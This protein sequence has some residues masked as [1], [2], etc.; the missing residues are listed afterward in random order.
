MADEKQEVK[1][2]SVPE[3]IL[4]LLEAEGIRT[5]IG[6]PDP[7][8]ITMHTLAAKR[9]WDVIAPHHEQTGVF[10][11]DGIWRM[12]GKPAVVIGNEGPGVANLLPGAVCA[13]K[14]NTPVI[15]IA[16]Q[17]RRALDAQVARGRFQYTPQPRFFEP[18]MKFVGIIEFP[19]QVDEIFH[20]AFRAAMS[21]TPGPVYIEYPED[22]LS[23]KL[24]VK[25]VKK[26][27]QYR[28][29]RRKADHD[30]VEAAAD[31]ICQSKNPVFLIGAGVF[32][33]RAHDA[34]AKLAKLVPCPIIK[35]PA[36]G[37]TIPGMEH[38]SFPY[39][40]PM[41]NEAIA[42]SD[43]VI[44]IGTE[45]GEP[46]H[47]GF[48]YHWSKGNVDR[49][50]VR[51]ERDEKAMQANR[52]IDAPLLGDL[53]DVIPQLTDALAKRS[54]IASNPKTAIWAKQ[55]A[56][57]NQMMIDK[58]PHTS[59]VHP[60]RMV[61]E[62]TKVLPKDT[63]LIRDGGASSM[64]TG[65]YNQCQ[66]SDIFW[67]SNFGHLGTGLPHAIGAQLAVGKNRRVCLITG[68]S[69]LL[70]HI[71]E[72]ETAVR[73]KLPVVVIVNSDSAWGLEV[74][75]Y[76]QVMGPDSGETEAHWGPVRF[77]KIA[78]GFGA[79]GEYVDKSENVGPAVIRA[80][81]SGR[82]A[83]VQVAVDARVNALRA[84]GAAEFATWYGGGLY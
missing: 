64:W 40:Y 61:I 42:E 57:A 3:R 23:K 36:A 22:N 82:P 67:C 33:N 25:P 37:S 35:T 39:S 4:Q 65:A 76:N 69:A 6:I 77:D 16:G 10:M 26:P 5:L 8:F 70:F 27:E 52:P 28:L 45:L 46:I 83:L 20:E 56:E 48:K 51:I 19:W 14:E 24:E 15:I 74:A 2:Q 54:P 75:V 62:A 34:M 80:L 7:G 21:G 12:T 71:S 50:W 63:V 72:L 47:F 11:C 55:L 17:R 58:A 29:V 13:S 66:T 43:L 38:R 84:P 30:S 79:H 73:K 81:E 53:V 41:A 9:G 1:Q 18:A 31:L 44:A 78:E 60:G 49:K 68:D 32:C 59:P